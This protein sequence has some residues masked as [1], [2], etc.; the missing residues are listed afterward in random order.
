MNILFP[1][2]H[3]NFPRIRF[4]LAKQSRHIWHCSTHSSNYDGSNVRKYCNVLWL[5]FCF[6][7]VYGFWWK[8][9]I[10]SCMN[11]EHNPMTYN[12]D[13]PRCWGILVEKLLLRK[14]LQFSC[15]YLK[16]WA[17]GLCFM[18]S[19]FVYLSFFNAWYV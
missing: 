3:Y 6:D 5:L 2:F 17:V 15:V 1:L 19:F 11:K 7:Q 10:K 8:C 4:I 13:I 9:D 12:N 16:F 18:Q 14:H